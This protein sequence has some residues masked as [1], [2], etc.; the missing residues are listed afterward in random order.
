MNS[1]IALLLTLQVGYSTT[2]TSAPASQPSSPR[3]TPVESRRSRPQAF[4]MP[5]VYRHNYATK[6]FGL[7]DGAPPPP[8]IVYVPVPEYFPPPAYYVPY[9]YPGYRRFF[10][11]PAP[12][13]RGNYF[14]PGPFFRPLG[15]SGQPMAPRR[16]A[17][18]RR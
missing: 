14:N 18:H 13:V 1:I 5:E 15:A 4:T 11:A 12:F 8:R 7:D 16:G 2:L 6:Y 17:V 10:F 9:Y 3:A